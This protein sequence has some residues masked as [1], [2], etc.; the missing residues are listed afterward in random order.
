MGIIARIANLW[1]GF[2]SLFVEGIE[3]KNPEIVYNNAIDGRVRK[4][5]ELKTA[6]A[7]IVSLR[8]RL[9]NEFD[10]MSSELSE[11]G[12]QIE[13]AVTMGEDEAALVLIERQDFL[14]SSVVT[15][16]S[17]LEK[18]RTQAEDAKQGLM[19]FQSEIQKLKREKQEMIAKKE[20]AEAR[21]QIQDTL[22][23]LSVEA[24]VKALD[25][26]RTSIDKLHAEADI[27]SEIS[28]SSLDA[29]LKK[30]R[31]AAGSSQAKSKLAEM[32][33]QMAARK[34]ES[35]KTL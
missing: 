35:A 31:Q 4:Y 25:N 7:G 17:E 1:R 30:V 28:G 22:S 24:D 15:K 2:L 12:P 9:R 20:T 33:R 16:E 27:S 32:K 18:V 13:S 8:N 19:T 5:A 10:S 34:A 29:R 26:V 11:L 23:G 21:I 6:V 3:V 14:Q